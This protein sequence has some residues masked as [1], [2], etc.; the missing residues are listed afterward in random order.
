MKTYSYA[1][2]QL[3]VCAGHGVCVSECALWK[4]RSRI[5]VSLFMHVTVGNAAPNVIRQAAEKGVLCAAPPP[6][7]SPPTTTIAHERPTHVS[8]TFSF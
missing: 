7:P 8:H 1:G 3:R 5:D 4:A 6:F 2:I